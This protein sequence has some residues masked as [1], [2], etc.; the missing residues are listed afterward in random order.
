MLKNAYFLEKKTE[1]SLQRKGVSRK[2][3]REEA[4]K[5]STI[6]PLFTKSVPC[7]KIQVEATAPLPL[8]ADANASASTFC[9]RRL[10]TPP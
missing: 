1:K 5:K 10:G 6:Y 3:S 4:T 8:A 2:I 7:M 9:L